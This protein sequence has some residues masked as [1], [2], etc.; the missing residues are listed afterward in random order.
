MAMI[1]H[2]DDSTM[3]RRAMRRILESE[4]HR[5]IEAADGLAALERYTL[6][7]PDLV[8]L[9][10]TMPGMRGLEVL[11]RLRSLGARVLIATADLQDVTRC[12]MLSE[13]AAGLLNKP[14]EP[15]RVLGSVDAALAAQGGPSWS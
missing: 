4:G 15:E 8:L 13:G 5:V 6:D 11:R 10:L 12:Q 2:V 1:L 3:S 7:H 9:D 14:F